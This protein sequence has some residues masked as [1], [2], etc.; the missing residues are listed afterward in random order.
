[1]LIWGLRNIASHQ[2][3]KQFIIFFS[4]GFFDESSKEQHLFEILVLDC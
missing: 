2:Y 3:L 1:V 4:S